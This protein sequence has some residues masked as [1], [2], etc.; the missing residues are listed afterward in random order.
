MDKSKMICAGRPSDFSQRQG[1]LNL[2]P[3]P[4]ISGSAWATVIRPC[5]YRQLNKFNTADIYVLE[6]I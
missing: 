2:S 4:R 6:Q 3:P 1:P 5:K